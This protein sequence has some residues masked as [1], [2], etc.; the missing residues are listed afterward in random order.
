MMQPLIHTLFNIFPFLVHY[1]MKFHYSCSPF[2]SAIL[3]NSICIK[4]Y[5]IISQNLPLPLGTH[6]IT[7][8]QSFIGTLYSICIMYEYDLKN[9]KIVGYIYTITIGV[10]SCESDIIIFFSISGNYRT[11]TKLIPNRFCNVC[12]RHPW[13]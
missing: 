8:S 1:E 7:Y 6:W 9:L 5:K 12:L 3:F 4:Y 13:L 10:W 2:A 11:G